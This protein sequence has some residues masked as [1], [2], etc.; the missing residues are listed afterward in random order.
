MPLF[1]LD[2]GVQQRR[3]TRRKGIVPSRGHPH[4]TDI[5]LSTGCAP[6][7][8]LGVQGARAARVPEGDRDGARRAAR[9]GVGGLVD[10]DGHA[11]GVLV[12]GAGR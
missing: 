2:L 7:D 8:L 12:D 6:A 10:G 4:G 1:P 5:R 3:T 9:G 11:K